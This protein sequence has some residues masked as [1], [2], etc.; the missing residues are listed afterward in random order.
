ML[1]FFAKR[2]REMQDVKR[3]ERGFTL[4]ELLVVVI[5]IGILASIAIPVFLSQR[6]SAQ[7]AAAKSDLRNGAAAATACAADNNGSYNKTDNVCDLGTL[8]S[9]Y[10]W[11]HT[12]GVGAASVT[13]S[14]NRWTAQLSS[15][16]GTIFHFDTNT[17]KV[18][19]IGA[20]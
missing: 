11:K 19:E 13:P 20:T 2:L 12:E 17:G 18:A 15:E 3:D 7:E 6:G 1:N 4:I 8:N 14:E 9:K 10:N 16:N 5:I